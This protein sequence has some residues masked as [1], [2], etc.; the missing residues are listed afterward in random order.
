MPLVRWVERDDADAIVLACFSD[1]GLAALREA[2]RGRPVMGIAESGI[3]HAMTRGERFGI[4][5]L[6]PAS[7]QR[8]R[9]YV[10]QMG[11]ASRYADSWPIDATAADTTG[12]GIRARMIEAGRALAGAARRRRAGAGLRRYGRPSPPDRSR[13]RHPRDRADTMGHGRRDRGPATLGTVM[14]TLIGRVAIVTGAAGGIGAAIARCFAA[15]GARI[16]CLDVVEPDSVVQDISR[17]GGEAMALATDVSD[18][19][20]TLAAIA[21]VLAKWG[22]VDI[23]VNGAAPNDP[24]GTV[25]TLPPAEW[26]RVFAVQVTGAYYMSRAV[27]PAMIAAGHGSIIHIASQLGRVGSPG[28]PAYCAAKG[29]LI[30]LA[31]AM[32]LD[33]AA[34]GIRVNALSPGAVETDRMLFRNATMADARAANVPKHPIGRLGQPGEIASAALFLASDASSFMTGADLLIDGGYTAI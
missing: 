7:V 1:P 32:A 12:D 24:F 3:M 9:R 15:A 11:V 25:L 17:V 8:Q 33:H 28:R 19:A 5:A 6:S 31:K 10:R 22:R 21:Q 14:S 20:A 4:I 30:Q 23:L 29:A 34:Q 27:L 13:P 2:A 26:A 16:A 18:E